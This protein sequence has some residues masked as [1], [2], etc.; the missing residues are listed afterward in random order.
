MSKLRVGIDLGDEY[1]RRCI[2]EESGQE[3]ESGVC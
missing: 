1:S 3:V 2:L